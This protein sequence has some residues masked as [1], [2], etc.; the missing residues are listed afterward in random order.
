MLAPDRTALLL[1]A[2]LA[3]AAAEAEELDYAT[4]FEVRA[5]VAENAVTIG[6]VPKPGFFVNRLYPLKL[7]LRPEGGLELAK[8]TLGRDDAS[9]EATEEPDKARRADFEIAAAGEGTLTGTYDL[10]ICTKK[11]CSNPLRGRFEAD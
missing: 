5:E 10:V 9:F 3:P 2:L 4:A 7:E 6:V 8:T 11:S 1:A